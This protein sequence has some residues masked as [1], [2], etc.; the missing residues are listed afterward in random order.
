MAFIDGEHT[1]K[2]VVSDFNFCRKVIRGDGCIVFHDFGV[3]S[4]GILKICRELDKDGVKYCPL[5]L[6]GRVFV[7]F[8]DK[9]LIFDD[10]YL[11][12]CLRRNRYFWPLFK[13]KQRIKKYV[14]AVAWNAL[15][16]LKTKAK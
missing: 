10:P 12:A 7:I 1:C 9:T 2:A 3:I 11:S 16:N 8:F 14:P 4:L 5:K 13:V 6:D 15:R